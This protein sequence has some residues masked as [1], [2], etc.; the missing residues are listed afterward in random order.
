MTNS[1]AIQQ[2]L[3]PCETNPRDGSLSR[4]V[5]P[6]HAVAVV[7]VGGRNG[8]LRHV[9][10]G[11]LEKFHAKVH[12]QCGIVWEKFSRNGAEEAYEAEGSK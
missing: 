7:T 12:V 4:T 5:Q 8:Q 3:I 9:C 1:A 10:A 6:F 2:G 11:C